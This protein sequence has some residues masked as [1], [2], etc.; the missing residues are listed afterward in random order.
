MSTLQDLLKQTNSLTYPEQKILLSFLDEQVK[1][2]QT[3]PKKA[4]RKWRSIRGSAPNLL[5]G[6]DAQ[7]WISRFRG[8][9]MD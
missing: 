5:N 2:Q 7:V 1:Q 3:E 9:E 6:E 8:D 4:G